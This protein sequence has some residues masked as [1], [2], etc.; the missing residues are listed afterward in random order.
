LLNLTRKAGEGVTITTPGG[1]LI[2]VSFEGMRGSDVQ[3]GFEADISVEIHR[4]E[5]QR[6]VDRER[7]RT[8]GDREP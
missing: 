7:Q 4:D 6:R 5:V 2:H 3:L 8:Q 1:E